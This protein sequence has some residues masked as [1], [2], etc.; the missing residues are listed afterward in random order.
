MHGEAKWVPYAGRKGKSLSPADVCAREEGL[1]SGVDCP[2]GRP[3]KRIFRLSLQG[4]PESIQE[5]KN[6]LK[7]LSSKLE[8][9]RTKVTLVLELLLS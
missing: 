4:K 9:A 7:P 8:A 1:G 5:P 2:V 6:I 3:K